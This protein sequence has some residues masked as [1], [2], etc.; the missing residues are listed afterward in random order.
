MTDFENAIEICGITKKYDGFTL[1]N[2]SFNVPKGTIM[3]FI[4]QNGAAGVI[5]FAAIVYF[6]YGDISFFD[7]KK[8]FE[9]IMKLFSKDWSLPVIS[10]LTYITIALYYISYRIALALYRKGA[11]NYGQ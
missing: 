3:G 10:A 4:G 5:L 6:L 11:E 7:M 9:S 8:P 1:D 2:I